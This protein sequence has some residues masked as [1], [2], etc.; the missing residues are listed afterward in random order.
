M[1]GDLLDASRLEGGIFSL[2]RRPVDLVDLVHTVVETTKGE[3]EA[4]QTRTPGELMLEAD[5]TRLTQA[6]QNLVGNAIQHNPDGVPVLVSV[7]Q[8]QAGDG[9][10]AVIEVHDEGPGIA[11]DLLPHLFVR[12][13][14]HGDTA[15]LG[16]GLYL[17]R[18]IATAHDGE[19]TASS[20]PGKGT[21]FTL[22]LPIGDSRTL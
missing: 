18:G 3:R 6:L 22:T 17:A 11:A 20:E 15:G 5:P 8:R 14:A 12:H 4:I 21:T 10:V 7:G 19:L 13:S 16:L 1:V 2:N 9:P